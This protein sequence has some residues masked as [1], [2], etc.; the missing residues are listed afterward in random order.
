VLGWTWSLLNP[1]SSIVIYSVFVGGLLGARATT[2]NPSGLANFPL[3]L[4]CALLPWN[5]L[6]TGVQSA[7]PSLVSNANLIRKVYFPREYVVTSIIGGFGVTLLIELAVL[8]AALAFFG[9]VVVL[10]IPL[11]LMFVAMQALLVIGLGLA[12][13]VLNVWFRDIQ[14][15]A[16]IGFQIWFYLTPVVYSPTL[17][18][19]RSPSLYRLYELNPMLHFTAA[20]RN[21][22]YD[23]RLPTLTTWLA[24]LGSSLLV[25]VAGWL[26]FRRF[27]AD[28]AEE[29]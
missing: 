21:L 24:C 13:S 20:Y 2:G 8:C 5:F 22:L 10:R 26:V 29:L 11:V 4:S 9:E 1:I 7:I 6:A 25:L 23:G 17:V 3:F 18:K 19:Q 27:Q 28:L 16:T 14:H 12:L 15:F